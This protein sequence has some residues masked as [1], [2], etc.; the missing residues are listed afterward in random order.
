MLLLVQST[1][2]RSPM[3][4]NRSPDLQTLEVQ[5]VPLPPPPDVSPDAFQDKLER[6]LTDQKDLAEDLK[7]EL[8]AQQDLT[9]DLKS[10]LERQEQE[11]ERVMEQL[12]TYQTSVQ[13]MTEQQNQL[14]NSIPKQNETQNLLLWGIFGLFMLLI[15]GGGAAFVVFSLWLMHIQRQQYRPTVV[16]QARIPPDPYSYYERRPLPP[17]E[18][19]QQYVQYDVRPFED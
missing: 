13:T 8:K 17:A 6:D 5:P 9:A 4:E 15:V 18:H 14:I 10:Q 11:T 19:R 16:Y 2:G 3:P 1:G 7:K 12:Q